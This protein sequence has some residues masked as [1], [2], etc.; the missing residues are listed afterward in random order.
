MATME[1]G[2][3][4]KSRYQVVEQLG[5]GGMGEVFLAQDESLD[6]K[7]A[8]KSNHNLSAHASAQFLREARLLASLKH[9]NLPRVIDYFT[10]DDSQ[11]LVMDFIPGENLKE[12]VE[13]KREITH[14]QVMKWAS[15]LSNALTYLHTQNPPI[16]HRDIKPA[17]IKL[18]PNGEVVLVDFGI[19]KTG[20]AS[21]ETQTGA[22]AFSPG[23]APPEQVS[24]MRTGPY[25][26]QFSLAATLYYLIAKKPPADSA[27]RLMGEEELVT[28]ESID[29]SLPA[30][31]CT[32]ITKALSI[33]PEARFSTV[34][35]F[36]QALSS[37]SPIPDPASAQK[38]V[39]AS[40]RSIPPQI[41]PTGSLPVQMPE[42]PKKRSSS[43]FM[44]IGLLLLVGV[45]VGGYFALNALGILGG[46]QPSSPVVDTTATIEAAAA[47][48]ANQM[49]PT[50]TV[51]VSTPTETVTP[52][53]EPVI[54]TP[55]GKSNKVAFISNRQTDG[56][57]QVWLMEVGIDGNDNLVAQNF[58]QLTFTAGD[59]SKPS[60]S[61]D[62]TKLIFSAPSNEYSPNGVPFA[63]DIWMLDLTK[64]DQEPV[65]LSRMPGNDHFAA[66]SPNDKWIAFTSYYREDKTPQ[67]FIMKPDG[68]NPKRL[69]ELGY[70]ESYAAWSPQGDFLYY[71]Y[72]TGALQVLQMRDQYQ[73]FTTFRKFD[74]SSNEGRLG[75]VIEPNV[76]LDGNL[77]VYTHNFEGKTN[78]QT[79][80]LADRGR[81]WAKVTNTGMDFAPCW[82]ADA[83]WIVFTSRRDGDA[84]IYI[85]DREG[86][87]PTNLTNLASNDTDPAWQP[88]P[89][90]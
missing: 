3:I 57:Q 61:P 53:P 42:I 4:L 43:I 64:P 14:A 82:S 33:K 67:L 24:G 86:G 45:L 73:N 83:K 84:E 88:L 81:T 76:S 58:Q 75:N 9:P 29:R 65:D 69:T 5:K 62:G 51:E 22:W 48:L 10:E 89:F 16:Y 36:F 7:V 20:E 39:I 70:S 21:Q 35:D 71:I 77:L 54:F 2:L 23:F 17:N 59:K 11:Y 15:E 41:H 27:R 72:A 52:T 66:W 46:N 19:A 18:T 74:Q 49:I 8:I 28:L 38:T 26:D 30:H 44:I 31:F 56:Y 80:V 60:W 90:N 34:S 78:I 1:P 32:A 63:D 87:R 6:T 13:A 37:P 85:I 50:E 12:L 55:L 25:S 79:A 40:G 68:S 47:T